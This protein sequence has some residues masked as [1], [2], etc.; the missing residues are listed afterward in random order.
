MTLVL[1]MRSKTAF[2]KTVIFMIFEQN[3]TGT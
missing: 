1:G 2:T 3:V